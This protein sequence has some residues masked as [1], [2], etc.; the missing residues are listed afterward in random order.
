MKAKT[1]ML[2]AGG[3]SGDQL[4]AELVSA[5][6][7]QRAKTPPPPTTDF[8]PLETN[9]EPRFF[10]A[11][12][13]RMAAAGVELAFDL[14]AHSVIGMDMLR[15]LLTFRRLLK[16][17]V[18]LAIEREPDVIVCVDFQ[19]FNRLFSQRI[20]EYV[21]PRRGWFQDWQP[22]V[23]QYVSPQVWASREGRVRQM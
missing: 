12:G 20:K 17:L 23:V 13:Q 7:E 3:A 21:R 16:R 14:T 8:H 15:H 18:R 22:K 10:G 11:G 9:L 6:R 2:V 4:G 1:F 19:L 5:L